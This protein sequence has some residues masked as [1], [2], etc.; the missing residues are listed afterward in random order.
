M[1]DS[2]ALGI[3]IGGSHITAALIDFKRCSIIPGTKYRAKLDSGGDAKS[4]FKTWVSV[5][6]SAVGVHSFSKVGIAIPGPFDYGAGISLMKDQ[7]KYLSLYGLKLK[8][9]LAEELKIEEK[10]VHFINDAESFLRGEVIAG[11]ARG[12]KSAIGLTLGTGLGSAICKDGIVE[13]ADLWCVS[14]LDGIAEDYLSTRWFVKRYHE[15]TGMV[16]KDVKSLVEG[17]DHSIIKEIFDEFGEHLAMFLNIFIKTDQPESIILGG[18]I[19][20]SYDLFSNSLTDNILDFPF[21]VSI[22]RSLLGEDAGLIGAACFGY[23]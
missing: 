23:K 10:N 18:N 13:D 17:N 20:K 21:P 14:F 3:D 7:Q 11:G 19:S 16:I 12:S 15:L 1:N 9:I 22:Q 8:A 4:I 2:I 5:M 6:K